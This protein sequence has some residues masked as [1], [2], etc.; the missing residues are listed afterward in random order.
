MLSTEGTAEE[1]KGKTKRKWKEE[2]VCH[3]VQK[4]LDK[5]PCWFQIKVAIALHEGDDII[6]CTT[7]GARKTLTFW[8]LL[9]MALSNRTCRCR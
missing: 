9:L 5:H 3:L 7:T 6:V 4:K 8:I 2:E 1:E